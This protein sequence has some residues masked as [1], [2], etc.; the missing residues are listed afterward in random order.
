MLRSSQVELRR[1]VLAVSHVARAAGHAGAVRGFHVSAATEVYKKKATHDYSANNLFKRGTPKKTGGSIQNFVKTAAH[2]K[3]AKLAPE[4][5]TGE[6]GSKIMTANNIEPATLYQYP[7]R[8]RQQLSTLGSF[9]R[10]QKNELFKER[11]TLVR[12]AYSLPILD[13]IKNGTTTDSSQNR[14]CLLGDRG[15]GKSSLIAQAQAFALLRDYVVISVP[16]P[17]VLVSGKNDALYNPSHGFFAQPMYVREWMKKIAKA[18]KAVLKSIPVTRDLTKGS[19]A[20]QAHTA[21]AATSLYSFLLEGRRRRDA[22]V[23]MDEFFEELSSQTKAPVLFT[24]DD[25]NVFTDRVFSA[26]RD[27]DNTP[28]YHGKLQV[29]KY[30]LDFLS[31]ARKFQSGVILTSTSGKFRSN[32]TI[33]SGLGLQ[34]PLAYSHIERYDNE[35]ASKF[36]GVKPLEVQRY[37]LEETKVAL[38]FLSTSKVINNE[39]TD[40]YVNEQY[41]V[42]GNGNPRDLLRSAVEVSY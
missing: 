18:N 15:V 5:P 21:K 16:N 42:S 13:L 24:L 23:V 11:T 22:F 7:M 25:V 2:S 29:P 17:E 39:V 28:I 9:K 31:G 27:T 19:G 20:F 40:D 35:L 33:T 10:D 14:I 8:V 37:T 38:Q 3:L 12:E 36:T 30:F 41:I 34:Q 4:I 1:A 32:D 26:N 6:P